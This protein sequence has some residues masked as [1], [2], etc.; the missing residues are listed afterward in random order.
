[1]WAVNLACTAE[2]RFGA[3]VE[4]SFHVV[5]GELCDPPP[6]ESGIAAH[7]FSKATEIPSVTVGVVQSFPALGSQPESHQVVSVACEELGNTGQPEQGVD[8]PEEGGIDRGHE[9]QRDENEDSGTLEL[10]Q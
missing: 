5:M 1:M 10:V 9:Q 3:A 8:R 2:A 4:K 7:N 6:T